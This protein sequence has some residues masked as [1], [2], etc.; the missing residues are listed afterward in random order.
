MGG[1]KSDLIIPLSRRPAEYFRKDHT[2]I[3]GARRGWIDVA[4]QKYLIDTHQQSLSG[5]RNIKNWREWRGG[6]TIYT[7]FNLVNIILVLILYRYF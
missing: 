4:M 1:V 6:K 2:I 5:S 7:I 3:N